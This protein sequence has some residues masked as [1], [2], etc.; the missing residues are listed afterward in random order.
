M[1]MMKQVIIKKTMECRPSCAACC[2]A[3]SISPALPALP[4]GKAAGTP[5]PHLDEKLGC[6][7]FG[8]AERP[9]TC[10]RFMPEPEYCGASREE[11]MEIL[12]TL[13]NS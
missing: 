8:K 3:I 5:C 4:D 7:L 1:R 9:K 2:I 13:E 10:I 6:Q 12:Q 11:A